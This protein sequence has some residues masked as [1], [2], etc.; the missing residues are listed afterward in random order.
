MS[1]A[2]TIERA[3]A[4]FQRVASAEPLP[5]DDASSVLEA[6]TASLVLVGVDR[7]SRVSRTIDAVTGYDGFSHTY[8][9]PCRTVDGRHT[10]IDYTVR[11]GVH[12]ASPDIYADRRRVAIN[13]DAR[14]AAEL[15][16]CVRA[17]IGRPLRVA[18]LIFGRD[19]QST[20]IGL[21]VACLPTSLR[22]QL[23][24][25]RVGPCISPNTL[26]RFFKVNHGTS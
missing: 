18:P 6:C 11:D 26:A 2:Q 3:L 21:V 25:V 24:A 10:V 4:S 8:V 22:Q 13:L 9:D 17:R 16:G 14:T 1:F 5:P 15:W 12:W 19:S 20:C 23:E 7:S